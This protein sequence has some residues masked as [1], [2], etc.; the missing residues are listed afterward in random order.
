ML[1]DDRFPLW[2]GIIQGAGLPLH[3]CS[4]IMGENFRRFAGKHPKHLDRE[5]A[6]AYLQSRLTELRFC[7][8]G[9]ERQIIQDVIEKLET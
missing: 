3:V 2:E 9:G 8:S 4:K 7:L 1:R 5:K 6:A